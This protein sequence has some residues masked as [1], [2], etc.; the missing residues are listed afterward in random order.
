MSKTIISQWD[1]AAEIF[2]AD[3]DISGYS[4]VNRELVKQR[5]PGFNGEKVLDLGCGYGYYTNYFQKA[6]A[7]AVGID[8]S[9]AMIRL[10]GQRYPGVDFSL[11]DINNPLPYEDGIFD[12]VFCNMVL[13]D[14]ENIEDVIRE[15]RRVL[16]DNGIFYYSIVHPVLFDGIWLTDD[17]GYGYA[18]VVSKYLAPYSKESEFWGKTMHFHRPISYYLN[19]LSDAGF[20][21]VHTEEPDSYDGIVESRDL[22]LFFFAEYRKL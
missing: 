7:E 13:M 2:A 22:T 9:E 1:E 3:Q 5:F 6:G 15:V 11:F 4:K 16:K 18:K 12:L 17:K 14:I 10:A 21:L 19:V 8:G 20:S